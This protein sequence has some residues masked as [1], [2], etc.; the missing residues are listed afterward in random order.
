MLDSMDP[1]YYVIKVALY[2]CDLPLKNP[3]P[4]SDEENNIRGMP[5]ESIQQN[6]T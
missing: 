3:K 5:I 2:L 6:S 4:Q 1:S